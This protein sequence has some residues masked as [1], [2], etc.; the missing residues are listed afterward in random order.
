MRNARNL[1][2]V[3]AVSLLVHGC[4]PD[5]T[6]SM[7]QTIT[8]EAQVGATFTVGTCSLS[9]AGQITLTGELALAGLDAR[10]IFRNNQKGTHERTDDLAATTVLIPADETIIIPAP[11]LQGP[12]GPAPFIV[13][14]FIDANGNPISAEIDL[15]ACDSSSFPASAGVSLATTV[16]LTV[17][18]AGCANHPGPTITVSGAVE[19]AA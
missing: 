12:P 1:W 7:T 2:T 19:F 13:V 16:T 3:L 4:A 10:L 6:D 8:A 5:G 14:Q 15:G 11:S 9:P 18:M 17:S